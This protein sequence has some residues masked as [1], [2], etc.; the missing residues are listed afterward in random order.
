MNQQELIF[1]ETKLNEHHLP[2]E[3]QMALVDLMAQI[4]IAVY[5]RQQGDM[6]EHRVE[7]ENHN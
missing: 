6:H 3:Q 5:L 1:E 2:H 7:P 4:I